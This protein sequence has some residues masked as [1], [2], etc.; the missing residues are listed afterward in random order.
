M[1]HRWGARGGEGGGEKGAYGLGVVEELQ[2]AKLE[3]SV[4]PLENDD[5]A[6]LPHIRI[7]AAAIKCFNVMHVL[8]AWWQCGLW[9]G[10]FG[11]AAVT[12]NGVSFCAQ[13]Q[14]SPAFQC[15]GTCVQI[16]CQE[17]ELAEGGQSENSCHV[18]N[19]P[20]TWACCSRTWLGLD[21]FEHSS[22]TDGKR[23][24]NHGEKRT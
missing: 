2:Q 24:E 15:W 20:Q 23:G 8:D 19:P 11:M 6:G 5:L 17:D 12:S 21:E 1:Y 22:R 14:S 10:K 13:I 16:E 3:A 7:S 4:A 18:Q 9:G